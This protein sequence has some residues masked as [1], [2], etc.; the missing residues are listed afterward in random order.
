MAVSPHYSFIYLPNMYTDLRN[1]IKSSVCISSAQLLILSIALMT[2]CKN[3][4]DPMPSVPTDFFTLTV[5]P[6]V[7]TSTSDYWI[8]ASSKDGEWIDTKSYKSGET[9]VLHGVVPSNN[10][11]ILH[12][13][14]VTK[15]SDNYYASVV[16]YGEI[17]ANGSWLLKTSPSTNNRI[18]V[19]INISNFIIQSDRPFPNT[20]LS[21]SSNVGTSGYGFNI[22]DNNLNGQFTMLNSPG[23]IQVAVYKNGVA[24]YARFSGITS[25]SS[26]HLD[27]LN[28]LKESDRIFTMNL[29]ENDEFEVSILAYEPNAQFG[30]TMYELLNN[31]GT[32]NI[33][34]GY[35][36]GFEKYTTR[37]KVTNGKE[38]H[39]IYKTSSSV[40]ET[41][42]FPASSF[43]LSK[44]SADDFAAVSD[45]AFDLSGIYFY[46]AKN[47]I[48]LG[49][50]VWQPASAGSK[51]I[52]FKIKPFPTSLKQ[53]YD[54][55]PDMSEISFKSISSFQYNGT[56]SYNTIIINK[57]QKA[58]P[59]NI[60]TDNCY[61]F[62][63]N[64][65]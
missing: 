62:Q 41:L 35:D 49:W 22:G 36:Q 42:A 58:L 13:M 7:R 3:E 14:T 24:H 34:L 1:F 65:N 44:T 5:D 17:A 47:N 10:V 11:F 19:P 12:F 27:A 18:N 63:L 31:T 25:A 38:V 23:N 50:N 37:L 59:F 2:S 32:T 46:Y 21:I 48:N 54:F 6:S 55:L 39:T 28:D 4:N 61:Q 43:S 51:A 29:P 45:L 20:H 40:E 57:A 26:I 56:D 52:D 9:V 16:S 30:Y 33:S 64:A 8:M 15:Q 60:L 53:K